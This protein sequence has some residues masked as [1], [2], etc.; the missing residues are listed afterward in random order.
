MLLKAQR[1][2]RRAQVHIRRLDVVEARRLRRARDVELLSQKLLFNYFTYLLLLFVFFGL[3][4]FTKLSL[5]CA[6]VVRSV[7]RIRFLYMSY[8][9][10]RVFLLQ[11]IC[12][13][14]SY[15]LGVYT[16]GCCLIYIQISRGR[17]LCVCL[18]FINYKH[19]WLECGSHSTR[20]LC[21]WVGCDKTIK[22]ERGKG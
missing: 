3:S 9:L 11:C 12:I 20:E 8:S 4:A 6:R 17:I 10:G 19:R 21:L 16:Y 14:F 15:T 13:Q 7:V 5:R 1:G 2:A 22:T 18:L